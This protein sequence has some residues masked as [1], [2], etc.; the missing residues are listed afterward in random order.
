MFDFFETV[1]YNTTIKCNFG[2]FSKRMCLYET[3]EQKPDKNS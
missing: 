1:W 2:Y 3:A